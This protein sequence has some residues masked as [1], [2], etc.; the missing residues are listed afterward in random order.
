MFCQKKWHFTS[1]CQIYS[2]IEAN[3]S[4][5]TLTF[6]SSASVQFRADPTIKNSV[7]V[8]EMMAT[9]YCQGYWYVAFIMV[10]KKS[11]IS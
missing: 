1:E 9:C 10:Y 2:S 7:M 8:L 4:A 5:Y 11:L 6:C 3:L